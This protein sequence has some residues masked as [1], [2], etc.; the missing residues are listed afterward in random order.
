MYLMMKTGKASIM[1][2]IWH[3]NW[4]HANLGTNDKPENTLDTMAKWIAIASQWQTMFS[5]QT[6]YFVGWNVTKQDFTD[7]AVQLS[8][9]Q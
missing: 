8:I 3:L 5:Q 1:L 6:R 2:S 4:E 7:S 9:N